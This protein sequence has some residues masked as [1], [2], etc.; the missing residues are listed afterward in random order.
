MTHP[1]HDEDWQK[2]YSDAEHAAA[3]DRIRA[4]LEAMPPP[5]TA[6]PDQIKAA[7]YKAGNCRGWGIKEFGDWLGLPDPN[8]PK[9]VAPPPVEDVEPDFL[10]DQGPC[11]P[12]PPET[13]R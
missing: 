4:D 5:G 7:V 6:T 13:G 10:C 8:A 9:S 3:L 2:N 11:E 12:L 1:Q